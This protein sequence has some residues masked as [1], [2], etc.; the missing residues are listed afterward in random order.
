MEHW[1]LGEGCSISWNV[2]AVIL[3]AQEWTFRDVS[4]GTSRTEGLSCAGRNIETGT[5][6][7]QQVWVKNV[8]YLKKCVRNSPWAYLARILTVWGTF[9][10][11]HHQNPLRNILLAGSRLRGKR[12]QSEPGSQAENTGLWQIISQSQSPETAALREARQ[13]V[14]DTDVCLRVEDTG[15]ECSLWW[16]HLK[17]VFIERGQVQRLTGQD[18]EISRQKVCWNI[19]RILYW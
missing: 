1:E 18:C 7:R 11:Q 12:P 16:K 3:Q 9:H 6:A 10:H 13:R 14:R 8:L 17:N 19:A 5:S 15:K 4:S 2:Q